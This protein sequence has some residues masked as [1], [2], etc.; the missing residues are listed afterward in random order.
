[1]AV[2]S[3]QKTPGSGSPPSRSTRAVKWAAGTNVALA[4][5]LAVALVGVLQ[6][7]GYA[8]NA[9]ADLT[10]S[11]INSLSEGTEKLLDSLN[12]EVTIV[13]MYFQSDLEPEDQARFRQAVDDLIDLYHMS[14]PSKVVADSINPLQDHQR[15][16]ELFARLQAI[17]KF[18]EQAKPYREL[19]DTFK[20][21]LAPDMTE[22]LTQEQ[23]TLAGLTGTLAGGDEAK[24]LGAIQRFLDEL[25]QSLARVQ[26]NLETMPEDEVPDYAGAVNAIKSL[27]RSIKEAPESLA[28]DALEAFAARMGVAVSSLS[29]EVQTYLN[30]AAKPY[31][32]LAD[33]VQQE[34]D[35][36]D[37]LPTLELDRLLRR[38]SPMDNDIF[39][40]TDKDAR[41]ITFADTWPPRE[42][43]GAPNA[44]AFSS[45]DFRGEEKISSAI[46]QI[47][48]EKKPA[49]VF[50]RYGGDPL[51]FGG[52]R[53]G[54]P[55][56]RFMQMK[57]HLESLNFSVLEWDLAQSTDPPKIDPKPSEVVYVVLNPT[58]PPPPMGQPPQTPPFGDEQRQ[59]VIKAIGDNGKALFVAGWKP[60][61]MGFLPAPYEFADYLKDT[62]GID[63][64]NDV[65]LLQAVAVGPNEFRFVRSPWN[66][67]ET[68]PSHHLIVKGLG[69][70]RS[71]FPWVAPLTL[72]EKAP[73]GVQRETLLSCPR[74]DGL[75]GVKNIQ[76]YEEQVRRGEFV[77]KEPNDVLGPFTVGVAATKGDAK[78]VVI[79][80]RGFAEDAVA[81]ATG[82]VATAQGLGVVNVN[83]SNVT[84]LV[85]SLHWLTGNAQWMNLGRPIESNVIEIEPGPA[86]TAARVLVYGI[87]PTAALVCGGVV[88][89]IRRR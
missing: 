46:L 55:R 40:V 13:S 29:P 69:T 14:N 15:R 80:S 36:A 53:P 88:W 78:I 23:Q 74:S 19:I 42:T 50:V 84:L 83:P 56:A 85:N 49:V 22:L 41:I 63:V 62:W 1:M 86:L 35:K 25:Q 30:G 59:A 75:W 57:E 43:G 37:D 81:F 65:L 87:W 68:V 34:L 79:S 82:L 72:T 44:D 70:R 11:G 17:P 2:E 33:R 12:T 20:T 47:T 39:V 18:K 54:M 67:S 3:S 26:Q 31:R 66:M 27:C 9:K 6:Y 73:E 32:G 71:S 4:V 10:S 16:K 48:Q 51:F 89:F 52:F 45:R 8:Y 7:A 60:D 38:F 24:V 28:P 77:T 5:I 61:A 21:S 58:P 76:A 64:E